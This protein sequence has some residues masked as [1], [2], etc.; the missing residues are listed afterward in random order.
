MPTP[1][2][3][4]PRRIS[5]RPASTIYSSS[6]TLPHSDAAQHGKG[7]LFQ[8]SYAPPRSRGRTERG[9]HSRVGPG[10]GRFGGH[11][12]AQ[13]GVSAGVRPKGQD[14]IPA[15]AQRTPQPGRQ[16]QRQGGRDWAVK[17]GE[18]RATRAALEPGDRNLQAN[19]DSGYQEV[20]RWPC[21]HRCSAPTPFRAVQPSPPF[22]SPA[23]EFHG[24]TA[25]PRAAPGS[26]RW[27]RRCRW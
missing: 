14:K 26:L 8:L 20:Q 6:I 2:S 16:K 15:T 22:R 3:G 9:E 12:A 5:A 13:Y 25:C 7:E 4:I 23:V 11:L 21:Q 10:D 1:T 17:R 18:W 27:N 19:P 24:G